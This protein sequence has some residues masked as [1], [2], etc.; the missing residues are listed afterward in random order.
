MPEQTIDKA[1]SEATVEAIQAIAMA[2]TEALHADATSKVGVVVTTPEKGLQFLNDYRTVTALEADYGRF[3][4]GSSLVDAVH[5][6]DDL[7]KVVIDNVMGN[8]ELRACFGADE[9]QIAD[10]SL[11]QSLPVAVVD[12]HLI[13][14]LAAA[15]P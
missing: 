4:D 1:R 11:I 6:I 2:G 10:S 9:T 3:V 13:H 5:A 8:S 7:K 14:G 12:H 15:Q